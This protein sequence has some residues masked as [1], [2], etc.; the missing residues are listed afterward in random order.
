MA[1]TREIEA[2]RVARAAADG[3]VVTAGVFSVMMGAAFLLE[4]LGVA[5]MGEPGGTGMHLVLSTFS[6]LL[7]AGWFVVGPVL[8]WRLKSGRF[9]RDGVVAL[10]LGYAAAG[11]LVAP[12]LAFG[13]FLQ[14]V[15]LRTTGAEYAGAIAFLV[16][17]IAVLI[18]AVASSVADSV[19]RRSDEAL[20]MSAV[21]LAA[22]AIVVFSAA[23]VA[24]S[25][26]GESSVEA[27][28]FLLFAAAQGAGVITGAT[29]AQRLMP[30]RRHESPSGAA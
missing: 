6:W 11:F 12:V 21:A 30:R 22:A 16:I 14:W 2:R 15:V 9:D 7:Q 13:A 25:I 28:G 26:G 24:V 23:V 4:W 10:V 27:F 17:L 8:A 19:K 18:A 20:P 3:S 1:G 29:V 5:P